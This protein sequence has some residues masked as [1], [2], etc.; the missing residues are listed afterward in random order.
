MKGLG[1]DEFL[2]VYGGLTTRLTSGSC[3]KKS[4]IG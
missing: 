1:E 4:F 2:V 3:V